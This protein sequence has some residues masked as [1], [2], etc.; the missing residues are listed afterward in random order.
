MWGYT[1]SKDISTYDLWEN[2]EKVTCYQVMGDKLNALMCCQFEKKASQRLFIHAPMYIA[3]SGGVSPKNYK[4]LSR[5]SVKLLT[6]QLNMSSIL[7]TATVVHPGYSYDTDLGCNTCINNFRT[8]ITDSKGKGHNPLLLVE[9]MAGQRGALC[10]DLDELIYII[11]GVKEGE[12][13]S[14]NIGACIDTCHLHAAG[15]P[16]LRDEQIDD[17]FHKLRSIESDIVLIHLND[18]NFGLG[19]K[20]DRHADLLKGCVFTERSLKTFVS[21]CKERNY[22]IILETPT[23]YNINIVSDIYKT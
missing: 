6:P 11:N 10:S 15:Y 7:G 1:Q 12:E 9:N 14:N 20:K 16:L 13:H 18:C 8:C 22:N 5:K 21:A 3:P 2:P 19:S 23:T 17:L 4:D